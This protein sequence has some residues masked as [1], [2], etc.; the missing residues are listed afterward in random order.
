MASQIDRPRE[1][2]NF[3]PSKVA[4]DKTK[5]T[6]KSAA[7][8]RPGMSQD[9]LSDIRKLPCC[10]C[11][12]T[13]AGTVHH[14]KQRDR[15]MGLRAQDKD[16]VPLCMT[17]HEAMER[18]GAKNEL[19]QFSKWGIDDPLQL[20]ADLWKSRSDKPKMTKIVLAHKWI[21]RKEDA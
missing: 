20:A 3:K 14:L 9:H 19:T 15:G 7:E 6:R 18:V 13:P 12:K 4:Q 16:G 21:G 1:Y 11:L 2:G 8:R 10:G 5:R 17:C